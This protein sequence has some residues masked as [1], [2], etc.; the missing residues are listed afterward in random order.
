MYF[1]KGILNFD[2]FE[3][4]MAFASLGIG[5][6]LGALL[7]PWLL[8]HF[9][10]Y[11]LILGC[12]VLSGFFTLPLLIAQSLLTVSLPLVVI[13]VLDNIVPVVWFTLRQKIVPTHLL[14]RVVAFTRLIA[15]A[16]IPVVA[17]LGGAALVSTQS[18]PLII[19]LAAVC[20]VGVG[21][22]GFLSLPQR[23]RQGSD[24]SPHRA[25]Q[26]KGSLAAHS[27]E[28]ISIG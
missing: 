14:G 13:G 16:P 12:T 5:A 24:G 6:S 11:P 28:D 15:F 7:T 22:L 21:G 25:P 17:I 4:G 23:H 20:H 19:L 8:R 18:M 26:A 3:I 2:T 27:H 10:F 9:P 1:L